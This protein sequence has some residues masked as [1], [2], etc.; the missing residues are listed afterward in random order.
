M[1]SSTMLSQ[2]LRTANSTVILDGR[3]NTLPALVRREHKSWQTAAWRPSNPCDLL[4]LL[5]MRQAELEDGVELSGDRREK[6]DKV[7]PVPADIVNVELAS[8]S[9]PTSCAA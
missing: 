5:T 9:A 6:E 8:V 3:R 7:V 4:H 1:N 2:R